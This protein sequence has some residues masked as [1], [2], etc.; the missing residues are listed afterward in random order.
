MT[1]QN[2]VHWNVSNEHSLASP[3]GA[4]V[5]RLCL[6][7]FNFPC[8]NWIIFC[9]RNADFTQLFKTDWKELKKEPKKAS[10]Q[11]FLHKNWRWKNGNNV[12]YSKWILMNNKFMLY[13]NIEKA[14]NICIIF[15]NVRMRYIESDEREIEQSDE[16]NAKINESDECMQW[17]CCCCLILIC[18]RMAKSWHTAQF[19]GG[20]TETTTTST[21]NDVH[22]TMRYSEVCIEKALL[23]NKQILLSVPLN[24]NE[25]KFVFD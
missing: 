3:F 19:I 13:A 9:S 14:F 11:I 16:R 25:A 17:L 20:T 12:Y 4:H 21:I 7:F 2:N 22:T 1:K 24:M 18:E 10:E 15:C 23:V 5:M 8:M 6:F